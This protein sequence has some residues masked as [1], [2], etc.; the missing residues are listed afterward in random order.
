MKD[1]ASRMSGKIQLST[2][3]HNMYLTAV[4]AAFSWRDVDYAQIVKSFGQPESRHDERRYSPATCTGVKRV[5]IIGRPNPDMISTSM[6]ERSNLQLRTTTRRF[7]RLTTAY[8][9][10]A[11][12]H[13]HA[14]S[15][16]FMS[17]NFCT[18]H[19]TLTKARGG[20]KTTPA[21]AAGVTDRVWK[22]EDMLAKMDPDRPLT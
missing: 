19:G 1:L 9:R 12:N 5:R 16:A 6:V 17:Y 2:D 4:R 13:A 8:S 14:V 10:K 15:L 3:G 18:P 20:I 22:I 21:M 11:E 7:T